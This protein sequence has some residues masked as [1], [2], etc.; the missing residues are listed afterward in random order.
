MVSG[1][2]IP[3]NIFYCDFYHNYWKNRE[4]HKINPAFDKFSGEILS[5]KRG[6]LK[7]LNYLKNIFLNK[8][9]EIKNEINFDV[10]LTVSSHRENIFSVN[11]HKLSINGVNYNLV[12]NS[13]VTGDTIQANKES[14]EESG[15]SQFAEKVIVLMEAKGVGITYANKIIEKIG[16][17][18]FQLLSSK[19]LLD[20]IHALPSDKVVDKFKGTTQVN[21]EKAIKTAHE[22]I[23]Q[24]KEEK[25]VIITRYDKDIYPKQFIGIE[26]QPII[27]YI[28]GNID[29]LYMKKNIAI[30]G[31][32]RAVPKELDMAYKLSKWFTNK[33]YVVTSGLALGCEIKAHMGCVEAKGK[34]VA[35]IAG[36]LKSIYL[37]KKVSL[38]K[39]IINNQGC[40]VSE[41]PPEEKFSLVK[42]QK[43]RYIARDRL[44]SALT[45]GIIV[46]ATEIYGGSMNTV[47]AAKKQGRYIGCIRYINDDDNREGNIKLMEEG[48][49]KI[50]EDIFSLEEFEEELLLK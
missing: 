17:D 11:K 21:W 43:S 16:L 26:K 36:G 14:I 13:V 46:V 3:T 28:K 34:T 23:V 30:I 18:R 42:T 15:I 8:I 50:I 32:R 7:S 49:I 9:N 22:I 39:K 47:K 1:E 41:Y 24:C 12:D 31:L 19:K 20:E 48:E 5:F 4:E 38:V 45:L 29:C 25:I 27:L 37:S 40:L 10:V 35:I 33:G 6:K 44:Q 2:E